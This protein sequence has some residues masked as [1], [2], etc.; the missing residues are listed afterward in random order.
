MGQSD[1]SADRTSATIAAEHGVSERTVRRAAELV[2]RLPPEKLDRVRR[3]EITL[4]RAK[5]E[6]RHEHMRE[7]QAEAHRVLPAAAHVT[8]A[9]WRTWLDDR[10]PCDLLLTDPP[11]STDIE[12]IEA[13]ASDWLPVALAKVKPTGRAYVCI[14][15]YPRELWAYLDVARRQLPLSLTNVLVWTYRNTLGP[16]PSHTYK[17]N[18]QAVLY[19]VGPDAPPL[20]CPD[21][22]EQF[23]VHHVSAPDGRQGDRYHTWQ[24]PIGLAERFV[25]H[26][27]KPG[28]LVYDCFAGTGTHLLAAAKLG[29]VAEG[30]DSDP[31]MV[32]VAIDRGCHHAE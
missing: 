9:E 8:V 7:A 19:F 2:E 6:V 16:K 31:G 11:Y 14:G 27:T 26:A 3:R 4:T 32:A 12:D 17:L 24:K 18:W 1:P 21:L 23:T 5:Q 29:R 25:R 22:M 13:F 28:D 20:D 30:C 15:A 10:D